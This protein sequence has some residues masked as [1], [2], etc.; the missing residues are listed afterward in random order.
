MKLD[1]S[2]L[3]D[4]FV[5]ISMFIYIHSIIVIAMK[6]VRQFTKTCLV[7]FKKYKNEIGNVV[8]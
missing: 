7:A 2:Q 4:T 3:L 6:Q 1:N 8:D 5:I